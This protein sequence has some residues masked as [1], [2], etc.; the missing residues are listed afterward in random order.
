MTTFASIFTKQL[1]DDL[2]WREAELAVMR[3]QLFLSKPA[4]IQE[5]VLLRAST[6]MMYAHYEG[7]CKFALGVYI[8]ALEN[9]HLKRK[10]LTWPLAALS[11]GE[12]R[13]QASNQEDIRDFY[14][15]ILGGF[16]A[17][18][19]GEAK[20]ERPAQIANLWPDLLV[21]WLTKLDLARAM[22]SSNKT[23]LESLVNNR[24]QIAHGQKLIIASRDQLDKYAHAATLAMHE[25]AVGIVE[26]LELETYLRVG[27]SHTILEHAI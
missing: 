27:P 18:L 16:N 6:A 20:Y 12:L 15:S 2:D 26:A 21:K 8:D 1:S 5:T 4:S 23:V 7:F 10:Q 13:K 25:V 9:R 24:N 11:L 14:E 17:A 3:K 22:V 19:E